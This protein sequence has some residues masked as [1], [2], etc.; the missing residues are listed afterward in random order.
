MLL[1]FLALG[2]AVT[3]DAADDLSQVLHVWRVCGGQFAQRGAGRD[4]VS[5]GL[6]ACDELFVS[7]AKKRQAVRQAGAS[8]AVTQ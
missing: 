5:Y 3:E 7:L 1:M 4:R 8:P 6:S 2:F